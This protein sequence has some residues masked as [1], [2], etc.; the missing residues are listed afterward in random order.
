M[1]KSFWCPKAKVWAWTG[2]QSSYSLSS[3]RHQSLAIDQR[4][5]GL[6]T[7]LGGL[8]AQRGKCEQVI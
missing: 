4:A 7:E 1:L 8:L 3:L 5:E 6:A 2:T